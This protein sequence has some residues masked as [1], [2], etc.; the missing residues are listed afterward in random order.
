MKRHSLLALAIAG[1]LSVVPALN[2]F[3]D[4]KAAAPAA[5]G[6]QDEAGFKPIF[7]GKSLDGWDGDPKFWSVKDGAIT[8]QTTAENPT[9]GNTFAVY[10]KG[11]V[12]NF[13]LRF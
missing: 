13:E 2:L 9:K 11:D 6:A 7:G 3:A 10:T 8:G 4:Q 1:T 12:S 5:A